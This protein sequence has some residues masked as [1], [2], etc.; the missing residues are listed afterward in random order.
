MSDINQPSLPTPF[1]SFLASIS[2]F[3]A[4]PTVFHSI[5]SPHYS[6]V[7]FSV[8][9]FY[10]CLIS[11]FNY[12]SLCESLPQPWYNPLWLTGLK[13]STNQLTLSLSLFPC[14]ISPS[15]SLSPSLFVDWKT[16]NSGLPLNKRETLP[17]QCVARMV[18]MRHTLFFI[19]RSIQIYEINTGFVTHIQLIAVWIM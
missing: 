3:M 8:L 2:V 6:V 17:V 11:P 5:N 9:Q 7:V 12:I 10:L 14:C 16:T 1:Y 18:K 19:V 4:L 15:L 13:A